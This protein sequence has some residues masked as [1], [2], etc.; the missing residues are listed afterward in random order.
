MSEE[1]YSTDNYQKRKRGIEQAF[2]KSKRLARSPVKSS[3]GNKL[4]EEIDLYISELI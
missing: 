4:E 3:S 2:E 1:G